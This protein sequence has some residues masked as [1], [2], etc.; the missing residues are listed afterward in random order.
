MKIL[1]FDRGFDDAILYG[2]KRMTIR[3]TC[4]VSPGDVIGLRAW[5]GR[6]RWSKQY[7]IIQAEIVRTAAVRVAPNSLNLWGQE[8][9]IRVSLNEAAIAD[10]F[11]D[12][13]SMAKYFDDRYGLPFDGYSIEWL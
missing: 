12:W 10:G 6:P 5:S 13:P 1:I 3:Q 8:S 2:T 4:R 11:E 9:R 7:E